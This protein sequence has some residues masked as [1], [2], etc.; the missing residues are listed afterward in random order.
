MAAWLL[1]G[2]RPVDC[3]EWIIK[4]GFQGVSLLQGA[5]DMDKHARQDAAA[6]IT[7][8]KLFVTYH[9]NVHEKLTTSGALDTDFG[10]RMI[11]DVIWWH[12]NTGGVYSC[13]A[14]TINLPQP[15][16]TKAFAPA[17]NLQHMRMLAERLPAY[18]IRVGIEN[19]F[20][21]K[22]K[23]CAL[24]D[25]VRFKE[26]CSGLPIGML[27]D[28]AHA[29]IHVRSDGETGENEIGAY[30]GRLP[31][32]VLEVHFSDNLGTKDEHKQL[33]Y[34][35]LDL[36]ALFSALKSNGFA[37]KFT[38]EVCVDI[39]AGKYASDIRDPQ[40]TD[41]LLVSRDRINKVWS[42]LK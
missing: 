23:L 30:A 40:Q 9:G 21:G 35:N 19:S 8:A 3:I 1:K 15:D 29:N 6:A 4:N 2:E 37:G 42:D 18:G 36:P 20:G 38:V 25:M 32:E 11:D 28:A 16:G 22:N 24:S 26:Q 41:A 10:R 7:A 13:C 33:G 39:L 17:L 34:G 27:L 31:F 5:M 14:D 12:E